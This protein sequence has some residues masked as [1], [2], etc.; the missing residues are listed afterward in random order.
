MKNNQE[1]LGLLEHCR[2]L[3]TSASHD[4]GRLVSVINAKHHDPGQSVREHCV[5]VPPFGRGS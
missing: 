4:L 2:S 5:Q 3:V 1:Q